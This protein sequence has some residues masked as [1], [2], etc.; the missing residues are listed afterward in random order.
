M[1]G[2]AAGFTLI[3]LLVVM[4]I[5]G[6]VAAMAVGSIPGLANRPTPE[7]VAREIAGEMR[8]ARADAMTSGRPVTVEIVPRERL[9][10]IGPWS[11]TLPPG[12]QV[13]PAAAAR[14]ARPGGPFHFTFNPDGTAEDMGLRVG[15]DRD[16]WRI[17]IEWLT[18]HVRIAS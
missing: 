13:G 11:L 17:D 6:L 4:V 14:D 10:R 1:K 8:A 12:M 9:V 18:G 16:I 3:E 7:Q 5:M 2:G 15:R